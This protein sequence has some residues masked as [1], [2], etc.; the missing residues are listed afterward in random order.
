MNQT[1]LANKKIQQKVEEIQEYEWLMDSRS[2]AGTGLKWPTFIKFTLQWPSV[3]R[4]GA[5]VVI[6]WYS[7]VP[8][9]IHY[10]VGTFNF[11]MEVNLSQNGSWSRNSIA[12]SCSKW[13]WL[14][15]QIPPQC[16]CCEGIY[17]LLLIAI[18][19]SDGNVKP[20]DLFVFDKSRLM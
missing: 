12:S 7:A 18:G 2:E 5:E 1:G 9:S 11:S 13:T 20:G 16:I 14:K 6:A 4:C 15:S 3:R 19:P 10:R 17:S 8:S